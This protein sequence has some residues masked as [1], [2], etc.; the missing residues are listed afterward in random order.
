MSTDSK[1]IEIKVGAFVLIGLIVIAIMAIQFGRVGQGLAK[2]Y[3]LTVELSNAGGLVKNSDV[4][5]AGTKVGLVAETP[6]VAAGVIG[7]VFIKLKIREG[8]K[9]PKGSKIAVGSNG[10]LGDK[11]VAIDPPDNFD[12]SKFDLNDPKMVIAA[13]ETIKGGQPGGIDAIQ[14]E[15]AEAAAKLNKRLDELQETIAA[16]RTGILSDTNIKNL[17]DSFADIKTTTGHIAEASG[18]IDGI[19]NGAQATVDSARETMAGAKGIVTKADAALMDVRG[20]VGDARVA[21][22]ST[23]SILKA[24][25]SGPGTI[26]MLLGDRETADNLNALIFNIRKHGLLFYRD[27]APAEKPV[28]PLK[29]PASAKRD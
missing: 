3:T 24:A 18:K 17:S 15:G 6:E 5:M 13:G 4:L 1:A 22:Q 9:C 20:A 7:K 2:Y 8:I 23:Q 19:I 26:P 25:K 14:K 10:M 21:I 29:A 11:Y 12:E 16:L 27:N 28:P